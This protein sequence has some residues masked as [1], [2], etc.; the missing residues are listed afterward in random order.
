MKVFLSKATLRKFHPVSNGMNLAR[1]FTG[2][3]DEIPKS[4]GGKGGELAEC[5][6]TVNLEDEAPQAAITPVVSATVAPASSN[7]PVTTKA[8]KTVE[9]PQHCEKTGIV[10]APETTTARS[11]TETPVAQ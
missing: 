8:P 10:A 7:T 9:A 3:G 6:R 2:F 5:A 11:A 4:Y 1:E